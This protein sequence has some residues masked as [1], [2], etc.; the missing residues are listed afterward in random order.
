ME[1][2]SNNL[3][4]VRSAKKISQQQLADN[5]NVTRANISSWE[6]SLSFPSIS[7]LH[8]LS[9]YLSISIDNLLDVDLSDKQIVRSI[10]MKL[11]G[12]SNKLIFQQK[13]NEPQQSYSDVENHLNIPGITYSA[14]TLE[15]LGDEMSP[16]FLSGDY[17]V[18]S[19]VEEVKEIRQQSLCIVEWS[20]GVLVRYVERHEAGIKLR[21]TNRGSVSELISWEELR[22]LWEVRVRITQMFG[23]QMDGRMDRVLRELG[24]MR[25]LIE[26]LGDENIG[27]E[28]IADD[29]VSD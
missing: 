8:R 20:G 3:K 16:V 5:L 1:F 25:G 7:V 17:V 29:K 12:S 14:R 18:G 2:F 22:S 9:K 6:N 21:G 27:D 4:K 10:P 28:N 19:E 13:S 15:V 23:E 26:Q 24:E 11:N